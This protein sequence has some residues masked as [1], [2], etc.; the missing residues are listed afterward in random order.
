MGKSAKMHSAA[1]RIAWTNVRLVIEIGCKIR[2]VG[3]KQNVSVG[4]EGIEQV[5][6]YD[7]ETAT[8]CFASKITIFETNNGKVKPVRGV[9]EKGINPPLHI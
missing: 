7:R 6:G 1:K 2:Y 4:L 3:D 8:C 5:N 9:E